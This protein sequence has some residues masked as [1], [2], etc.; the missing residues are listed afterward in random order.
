M[1]SGI[2]S[3]NY[4]IDQIKDAGIITLK[5]MFGEYLIYANQKPVVLICD[6]TAYVKM[7]DCLK[8]YLENMEYLRIWLACVLTK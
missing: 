7:L 3:V 5:K 2:D 6:N 4:V 8:P 1:A